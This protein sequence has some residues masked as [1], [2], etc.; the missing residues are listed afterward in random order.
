MDM[1]GK[2]RSGRPTTTAEPGKKVT[3]SIRATPDLKGRLD[4]QAKANDRSLSQEAEV[5]L[6]QSFL[7]D[8]HYGDPKFRSLMRLLTG[9][10]AVIEEQRGKSFLADY[11]TFRIV[12]KAWEKIIV[13]RRPRPSAD[14]MEWVIGDD[15][16]GLLLKEERREEVM[17]LIDSHDRMANDVAEA[18]LTAMKGEQDQ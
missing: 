4:Q 12:T 9:A 5:R 11:E 6:E 17:R 10:A 7:A 15:L 1:K 3:L 8:A 14:F 16:M 13:S 2:R 18:I